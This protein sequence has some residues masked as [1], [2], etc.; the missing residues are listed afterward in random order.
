MSMLASGGRID[1][2]LNGPDMTSF[3]GEFDLSVTPGSD[4]FVRWRLRRDFSATHFVEV[5]VNTRAQFVDINY[6]DLT[7]AVQRDPRESI[8]SAPVP[9]LQSNPVVSFAAVVDGNLYTL[10][11]DGKQVAQVTETRVAGWTPPRSA[12]DRGSGGTV[13]IVGW[14]FYQLAK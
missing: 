6:V 13:R 14:R 8:A 1:L 4:V 3:V 11:V 12:I 2:T 7:V 10:Y 5:S 9:G